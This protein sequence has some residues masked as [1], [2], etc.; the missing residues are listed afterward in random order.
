[1]VGLVET[2]AAFA[3]EVLKPGGAFLAKTFQSGADAELMTESKRHYF[4]VR[5]LKPAASRLSVRAGIRGD[6]VQV[7]AEAAGFARCHFTL[8]INYPCLSFPGC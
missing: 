5:H 3:A 7:R 6:E 1:M 8:A 4:N 2:A